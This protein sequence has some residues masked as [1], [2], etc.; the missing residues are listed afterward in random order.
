CRILRQSG[1]EP[2]VSRKTGLLLDPYFSATKIAWLLDHTAGAR[3]AAEAGHLAFG[4]IDTYLLWWLTGGR[5]H[6]TGATNAARMLLVDIA[7]GQ[8]DDDLLRLFNVPRSILPEVR[9]CNAAFGVTEPSILGAPVAITGVA[10]DQ[11]AAIIGQACFAPGM[12]KAT[13]GT[14]CF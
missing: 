4:T 9:D 7:K 11:Q 10:G 6:A 2:A 5:A 1:H 8:F 14:G 12:V 3:R 13:Y